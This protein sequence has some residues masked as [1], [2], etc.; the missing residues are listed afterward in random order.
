MRTSEHFPLQ[1]TSVAGLSEKIR[2]LCAEQQYWV[3]GECKNAKLGKNKFWNFDLLARDTRSGKLV[4]IRCWISPG[5]ARTI[6]QDLL[7]HGSSLAAGLTDGM[8]LKVHAEPNMGEKSLQLK[9]RGIHPGFVHTGEHHRSQSEDISRLIDMH[10]PAPS[11]Q[12]S[13]GE[14][15]FAIGTAYSTERRSATTCNGRCARAIPRQ[16]RFSV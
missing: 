13:P 3:I 2:L 16:R 1:T 10:P 5:L 15:P 12:P 7:G 9:V 6:N 11:F 8:G 14:G 4:A